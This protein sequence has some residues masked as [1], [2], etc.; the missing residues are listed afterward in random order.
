MGSVHNS[1][2]LKGGD[3]THKG[4]NNMKKQITKQELY[5]LI[6]DSMISVWTAICDRLDIKESLDEV[7]FMPMWATGA[8]DEFSNLVE[9]A[10]DANGYI[11]DGKKYVTQVF[12][13]GGGFWHSARYLDENIYVMVNNEDDLELVYYDVREDIKEQGESVI[14]DYGIFPCFGV[15]RSVRLEDMTEDD[16]KIWKPLAEEL[17]KRIG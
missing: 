13:S 9:A 4:E 16:L 6:Q 17:H 1:S 15:V 7:E 10:L 12:S 8:E 14:S 2:P 5:N 3:H 11:E